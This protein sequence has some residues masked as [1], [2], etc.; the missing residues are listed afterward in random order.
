MESSD[1]SGAPYG[2]HRVL[3]P[4]GALPQAAERLDNDF[5]RAFDNEILLDVDTL[6]LDAASFRQMF[7][8]SAGDLQGVA[9]LVRQ[10][11]EARGKQHN[12]VTGSGGMLLG[13]VARVGAKVRS[14]VQLG[15]RVA[16][17]VSLT[18][19]PLALAE[20][21]EVRRASAQLAVRGQAVLFDGGPFAV[22]PADLP[23]R[24]VLAALDV[25]GAPALVART[26]GPGQHVLVLGAGGKS[27]LLCVSEARRQVGSG[28]RV[29]GVES[30]PAAAEQLRQLGICDAVLE[31][32]ARQPLALWR[33]GLA[34]N[35]GREFD[36]VVSC[37]NVEG[38]EMSAILCA[39]PRGRVVFFAMTTS[40]SRAALGAEGVGKDIELLI[41]NGYAAGHAE[42]T[43]QLLR[44]D[45]ALRALF[46]Q[47]YG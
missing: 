45:Q 20:I 27:G 33:A 11:V 19:T 21:L 25:C 31:L 23:E 1:R 26:S 39:K 40:F 18:L 12:P 9:A 38:A 13:T 2:A 3:S 4:E 47:R 24:V 34:E 6:N 30:Q 44:H 46:E 28:G 35:A 16:S 5:T 15:Q 8:A 7:E 22:M 32:D 29:V 43:L 42:L 17:L 14:P 41:G 10:T 37:V 36:L